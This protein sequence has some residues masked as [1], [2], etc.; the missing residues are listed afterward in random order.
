MIHLPEKRISRSNFI[1]ILYIFILTFLT[2]NVF[3]QD[4]IPD[5]LI[6]ERIQNIQNILE[7][8][9]TNANR[10]WYFW[11]VG[12]SVA[13][14]GQ[15]AVYFLSNDNATRQDMALGAANTF[16]GALGQV[17]TPLNPGHKADILAHIPESTPED[18]LKKLTDA[19]EFLKSIA[20][21][22]KEGRS[23]KVHSLLSTVNLCSGLITWLGFK[24]SVWA[25]VGNFALNTVITETQIL[26]QPTRTMKDYQRYCGK[27]KSG[28][29]QVNYKPKPIYYVSVSPGG[30][31]LR[32]VF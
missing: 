14:A 27:Y 32:I 4:T 28:I 6:I 31:A 8:G 15:G 17:F 12:Y 21:R 1:A 9:K 18:R 29:N 5:S 3:A 16:L 30:I 20:V 7:H 11:L 13:T 19:E 23:W 10:W 2:N 24:R 26:T 25:G 22:E